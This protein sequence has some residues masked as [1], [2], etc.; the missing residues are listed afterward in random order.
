MQ[1]RRSRELAKFGQ[2]GQQPHGHEA[3]FMG[4]HAHDGGAPHWH[5]EFGSHMS[6][7]LSEEEF[8]A[9]Q[10]DWRAHNVQLVTVGLDIGSSTSHLMFSRLFIRLVGE[11]PNVMSVVT[12]RELIWQSDVILTPYLDEDTIDAE[13]LRVFIAKAYEAVGATAQEVDSGAIILTG[14]ALK[15]KNAQALAAI[16]AEDAG[17]FVVASA[18]HH[19]EAV[20]AANGSGTVARSRR[21][22]R[23]I[24][25][26]DIGGGTT[27]MALVRDGEILGTA[28]IAIGARLISRDPEGRLLRIEEPARV[29]ARHL[30]IELELGRPLPEGAEAKIVAA[31]TDMIADL[32]A[33]KPPTGVAAELM[34]TDPLPEDVRPQA[35]AF[36]GGVSEFIFRRETRDFGDLGMPFAE[37]IRSALASR[38]IRLPSIVDPNLGIRATAIGASLAT[39]QVGVN[40]FV[41]NEAILP[42][43][44]VPV[45]APNIQ[46]GRDVDAAALTAAIQNA[47][48]RIDLEE[49]DQPVAIAIRLV[50]ELTPAGTEALA[51]AIRDALPRTIEAR[52]PFVVM[53]DKAAASSLGPVLKDQGSVSGDFITLE[54]VSVREFSFVDL[55]AIVRPAEVVPI[56]VKALLFAGGLDRRSV[57]QAL[58]AAAREGDSAASTTESA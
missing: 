3:G 6:E 53:L 18:G 29:L 17:H 23:T 26:V 15:R 39:T 45:L 1:Y 54:G 24:L 42:L 2:F 49:G 25:N 58:V 7:D 8:A 36:S 50:N 34:L 14:E 46:L 13:A 56:T 55:G 35:V 12:G 33:L 16:F 21:D 22:E 11:A 37:A 10:L 4:L 19:L 30:G 57:K 44:N 51:T 31:W 9:R 28:A 20:L 48:E 43:R 5:D 27:K 41:T 40:R 32:V 47:A 38:K 52:I